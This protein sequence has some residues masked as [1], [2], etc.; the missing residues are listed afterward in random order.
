ML[1]EEQISRLDL[2]SPNEIN[3]RY[4][5]VRTTLIGL[6]ETASMSEPKTE[7]RITLSNPEI[8]IA[9]AVSRY[10]ALMNAKDGQ[11]QY[12]EC[13]HVPFEASER[14]VLIPET[15][16]P[17]TG[18]YRFGVDMALPNSGGSYKTTYWTEGGNLQPRGVSLW[19][20]KN[21]LYLNRAVHITSPS[22]SFADP[23]LW[24]LSRLEELSSMQLVSPSLPRPR[25][26]MTFPELYTPSNSPR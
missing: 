1:T 22:E 25:R 7:T 15:P 19:F 13:Y 10:R 8:V 18:Y 14:L 6:M 4:D 12:F 23:I 11:M 24:G 20:N 16:E 17:G 3:E 26:I 21:R 9:N 5:R 2:L